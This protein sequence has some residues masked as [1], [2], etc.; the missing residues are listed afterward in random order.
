MALTGLTTSTDFLA[1]IRFN[2][3]DGIVSRADRVMGSDG[4]F[5]TELVDIT[6]ELAEQGV[7]I[8][9][10]NIEIGWI[11]YDGMF[12]MVTQHHSLGLPGPQPS[13]LH[14]EGIRLE[15][16]LPKAIAEGEQ[17]REF[18]S[19][20]NG[21]KNA[22]NDLHTAWETAAAGDSLTSQSTR[23]EDEAIGG[24]KVP[25]VKVSVEEFTTKNGTFRKP[26]F[27]ISEFVDRPVEW[28]I[29][30]IVPAPEALATPQLAVAPAGGSVAAPAIA[31]TAGDEDLPF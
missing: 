13:A 17:R 5:S 7:L 6:A 14:K 18:S 11:R 20:A 3:R 28:P 8:D 10:A 27:V 9:V 24:R 2:A 29:P 22:V 15:L 23:E 16:Y 30:E 12:N 1:T 21:V 25:V 31:A 19:N 4:K 26:N